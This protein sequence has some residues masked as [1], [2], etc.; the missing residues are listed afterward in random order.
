MSSQAENNSQAVIADKARR[1]TASV[2][3]GVWTPRLGRAKPIVFDAVIQCWHADFRSGQA[4]I[5][6]GDV[7]DASVRLR[8]TPETLL[9]LFTQ[10]DFAP[11]F[12]GLVRRGDGQLLNHLIEVL[13]TNQDMLAVAGVQFKE[14]VT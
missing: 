4:K 13:S 11:G 3:R 2:L 12:G 5:V 6:A 14:R 9:R 1:A 8:A 7:P 10:P